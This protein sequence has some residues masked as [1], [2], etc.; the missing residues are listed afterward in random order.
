MSNPVTTAPNNSKSQYHLV[1]GLEIHTEL[2]T[3]SKMFCSCTNDPFGASAPNTHTCPVCLGMPGGLPV[4]NQKAIEW[5]IKLGLFLGCQINL[6]SK[7]DRKNYFYP[8]LP[9]GYQIS[10]YDLPF[11][12]D[13]L[14][15]TSYGPVRITRIHLEEDTAKLQH[16][17]ID[18]KK[19]TL[20][21]FNRSSVPLVEIVS[22]PDITCPEQAVEYARAIRQAVRYL[23]IGDADMEKGGMRL[24]ANIS[25]QTPEQKAAHTLPDYKTEVKNINSFNF[26]SQAITYEIKRQTKLLDAG[27]RIPQQTLGFNSNKGS[28]FVQRAK[29]NAADY[30]YFPDPDLPTFHFTKQQ[31][32]TWRTELPP[33]PQEILQQWQE[34]YQLSPKYAQNFLDT[35]PLRNFATT[36]WQEAATAK[37]NI[38]QLA[39]FMINKKVPWSITDQTATIIAAFQKLTAHDTI[40]QNELDTIVAAVLAAHP[41]ETTRLQAGENKLQ[42]FFLGQ[43]LRQ[44]GKKVEPQLLI[45]TLHNTLAKLDK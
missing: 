25:L 42:G 13:G 5:T 29:E 23:S 22:E 6:T 19:V 37:I 9:K 4:A 15:Q 45:K 26:M 1:C 39:N 35:A 20:I 41:A 40:D 38:E 43:I 14:V 33:T 44:L 34:N 32:A 10:Q 3:A 8:D 30:R 2:K 28:T 12:Y 21:D 27:E 36:L 11:C 31:I 16:T 17:T 7:F 24:E 18:G